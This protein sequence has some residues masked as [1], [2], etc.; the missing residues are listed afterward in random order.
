MNAV[1]WPHGG[2]V[3]V[4]R[5]LA[6]PVRALLAALVL[7]GAAVIL[8]RLPL[9]WA[10]VGTVGVAGA[11][12]LLIRPSIGLLVLAFAVPF[13][14]IREFSVAGVSVG[15]SEA[16]VAGM[17]VAWI[18]RLV[19][20]REGGVRWTRLAGAI[21]AYVGVLC[22]SLPA[23]T[24]LVP[25][26]TELAKWVELGI[27][28]LLVSSELTRTDIQWTVAALL[29]AGMLQGMLGIYQFMRQV[30]PPGFVLMGRYMR[31]YGTF[32]QPN[33]YG[34]YLGLSLPLAYGVVLTGWREARA[35][36][37]DG[38]YGELAL[39]LLAAVSAAVMLAGLVMSWSRGALLGFVAGAVLVVLLQGRRLWAAVLV[40]ALLLLPWAPD[41]V[42]RVPGDLLE[43]VTSV[44][45]YLDIRVLTTVEI[46]DENFA[47]LERL[48]HWLAAWRMFEREP[49]LGVGTGQYA[50]V[51]SEVALPRWQDPLGHAHNYYLNVLAENGMVGVTAYLVMLGAAFVTLLKALR[52]VAGWRR[53]IVLGA[54]GMLGHLAVHSVVDNLYVHEMYLVVGM[55]LGMA[56]VLSRA[57]E[58]GSCGSLEIG[59]AS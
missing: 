5:R 18:L 15:I 1:R 46:T 26:L 56:A 28:Y 35:R 29:T 27:V 48:A 14:S 41:L 32:D 47:T 34:G 59:G 8:V 30:G 51:Y 54:L 7:L 53:G 38:E 58:G 23:V 52:Q 11:L 44:S 19:A 37:R 4:W 16:L 3:A 24:A 20:L 33:P 43:R 36:A 22:L 49:W 17:L 10:V 6:G 12:I 55:V 57:P 40:A 50:T 2:L 9:R 25:A 31:A 45:D 21:A 42:A 39:W 13:G